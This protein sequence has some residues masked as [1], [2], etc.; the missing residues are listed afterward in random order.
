MMDQLIALYEL[1]ARKRNYFVHPRQVHRWPGPPLAQCG[2]KKIIV[3][4]LNI[5]GHH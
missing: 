5:V 4:T 1:E 2:F 3:E